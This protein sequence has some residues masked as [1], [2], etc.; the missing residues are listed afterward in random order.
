MLSWDWERGLVKESDTTPPI[1]EGDERK[2]LEWIGQ[3]GASR[4]THIVWA[5]PNE[6]RKWVGF[7]RNADA[8]FV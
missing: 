4:V 1:F 3:E 8:F 7:M 6:V 5:E 2:L